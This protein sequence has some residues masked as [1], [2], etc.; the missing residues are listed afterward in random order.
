MKIPTLEEL[1]KMENKETIKSLIMKGGKKE[2][3]ELEKIVKDFPEETGL[4]K[5]WIE[6]ARSRI[7]KR[8]EFGG[9]KY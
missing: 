8:R 2:R 7:V 9:N 4:Q 3:E 1:E 5:L 6:I